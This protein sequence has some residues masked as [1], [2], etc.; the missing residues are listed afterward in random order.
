MTAIEDGHMDCAGLLLKAGA[1]HEVTEKARFF[2][3][4][5]VVNFENFQCVDDSISTFLSNVG[6]LIL[7]ANA[8]Y[9]MVRRR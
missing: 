6:R 3:S 5:I 9:R 7:V 4:C 1:A 8:T 2:M